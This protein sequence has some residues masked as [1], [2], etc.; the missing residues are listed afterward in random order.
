M[1]I[2]IGFF[3]FSRGKCDYYSLPAY[4]AAAALAAYYLDKQIAK[5]SKIIQLIFALFAV[6]FLAAAVGSAV[7]LKSIAGSDPFLW[8]LTPT[9]LFCASIA[10]AVQSIKGKL[11]AAYATCVLGILVAITA[12]ML[13]IM[14]KIS[15]LQPVGKYANIIA[16]SPT[17]TKIVVEAS[18]YHWIDEL[19]FQSGRHAKTVDDV[20]EFATL[21][22]Q[23]SPLIII[24]PKTTLDK[25]DKETQAKLK[26]VYIDHVITHKLTPG[27]AFERKGNLL[28][29]IP[30]V[31]AEVIR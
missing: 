19:S 6:A 14:P 4:P 16:A 20:A 11:T 9:V 13:Q 24:M 7:I 28:D 21:I 2:S 1:A 8:F 5:G 3:C 25:L 10:I 17:N 29:P 12:F 27:Y 23:E 30:V 22:N 26:I 18:L 31:V 15:A